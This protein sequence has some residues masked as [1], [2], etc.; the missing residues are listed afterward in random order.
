VSYIRADESPHVEYLK[1]TLSEMRD[2]T[3]VTES[4]QERPG[5]EVVGRIWD[6]AR[7]ESVGT[8]H[9][10]NVKLVRREIEHALDANAR[11]ADILA[12]FDSL[13]S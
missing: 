5:T 7:A 8:R 1:T 13:A 3:F 10:A 2:R 12:E 11:G 4:G 6:R 9:E